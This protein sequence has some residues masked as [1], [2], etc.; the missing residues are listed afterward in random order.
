M[1]IANTLPNCKDQ[2]SRANNKNS[3]VRSIIDYLLLSEKLEPNFKKLLIVE[4]KP[5]Y[6]YK[7][8]N[9]KKTYSDHNAF[10]F[11][12]QMKINNSNK[13]KQL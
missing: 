12:M 11:S 1:K 5:I 8:T 7:V 13:K 4:S 2:W 9:D 6:P 3:S 10:I